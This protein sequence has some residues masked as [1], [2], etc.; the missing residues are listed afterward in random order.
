MNIAYEQA[1][2]AENEQEIPVGCII[3]RDNQIIASAYNQTKK[4]L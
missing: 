4:K 2:L 3:I 1:E